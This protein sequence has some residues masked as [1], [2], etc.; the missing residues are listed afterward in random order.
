MIYDEIRRNQ[1]KG[2]LIIITNIVLIIVS[3][4]IIIK[5]NPSQIKNQ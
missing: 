2:H 3:H 4:I 1:T 5:A